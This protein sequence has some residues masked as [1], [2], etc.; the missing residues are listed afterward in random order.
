MLGRPCAAVSSS[1]AIGV[2]ESPTPVVRDSR[3][4]GGAQCAPAKRL[5]WQVGQRP[6]RGYFFLEHLLCAFLRLPFW[7]FLRARS[8]RQRSWRTLLRPLSFCFVRAMVTSA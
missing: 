5:A 8:F 4:E 3:P 1:S 7:R 6:A 2:I